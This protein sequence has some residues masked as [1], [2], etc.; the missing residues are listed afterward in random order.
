ML[1]I[2]TL[3]YSIHGGVSVGV[4]RLNTTITF[5][6]VPH[7]EI[8]SYQMQIDLTKLCKLLKF[9]TTLQQNIIVRMY[10]ILP[11]IWGHLFIIT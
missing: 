9:I 7:T 11:Y 2:G 5:N 10:T 3:M 1:Y 8:P 6:R 4:Y